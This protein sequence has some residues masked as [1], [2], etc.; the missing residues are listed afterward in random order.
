MFEKIRDI[1]A[2]QLSITDVNELTLDTSLRDD[3]NADSI[4]AVEII[5]A[6]EDIFDIE[7]EEESAEKFKTIADIVDYVSARA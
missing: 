1:I 2:Q 3:L 5:M 7:I 4:D 6:L